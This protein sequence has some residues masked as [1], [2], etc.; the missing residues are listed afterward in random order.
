MRHPSTELEADSFGGVLVDE[1]GMV[2]L[3]EPTNHFNGYVW[4]WPKGTPDPGETPEETA[5]REVR[6][7]TGLQGEIIARIPGVFRSSPSGWR[8]AY[9][10]MR[11]VGEPAAHDWET[12]Q[13]RWVTIAEARELIGRTHHVKGRK[14]DWAVLDAVERLLAM[15]NPCFCDD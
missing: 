6:E 1:H 12:A 8:N 3:R 4:T 11:P 9:F 10:L 14:R 7:E 5:V 13:V 15:P 2:L